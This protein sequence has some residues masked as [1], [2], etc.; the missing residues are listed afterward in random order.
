MTHNSNNGV[1]VGAGWLGAPL[2]EHLENSGWHVIKTSR[3]QKNQKGWV[4]FNIEQHI[5]D[6]NLTEAVWFFCIPPGRTPE[7]QSAYQEY[8]KR[9]LAEAKAK[10]A[11]RFIFCSTTGVYP[12]E[13]LHFTELDAFEAKTEK[14]S[15]L[16]QNERIVAESGL[17]TV[18]V[19]LGGLMGPKRHPGR[20]LSGKS[21]SSSANA[22]VNMV[23]QEDAVN[24]LQ[25]IAEI[26][27]PEPIINLV[28]PHHPTKEAFYDGATKQLGMLPVSFEKAGKEPRIISSDLL[29]KLGFK[30]KYADLF[31][32]LQNC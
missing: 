6:I 23:H 9:S 14:Q 15:R 2:A 13:P 30:F 22:T 24:G 5:C 27:V 18:I 1:V 10:Q 16:L 20:F 29:L 21:L 11:S 7:A 26:A 3:Q 31:D 25:F 32:A 17:N 8:L 19:R 28:T 12:D 4:Q